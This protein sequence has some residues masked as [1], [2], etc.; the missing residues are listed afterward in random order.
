MLGQPC[1]EDGVHLPPNTPPPPRDADRHPD[2]WTPYRDRIEF[3]TAQFLYCQTQ[4][5]APNID[6]LLDLW[7]STLLKHNEPPPFAN[8][9]DLYNTIDSTPLG[10]VP[11]QSFSLRYNSDEVPEGTIPQWMTSEYDVWFRD[12]HTIVKNMI[13]NPEY[14]HHA[15]V[16]PVQIFD[17]NGIRVYQNFMSGDWAWE[18]AVSSIVFFCSHI[19]DTPSQ[20]NRIK[21]PKTQQRMVQCL[22]LSS[23]EATKP[24]CLSQ[25]AT[26]SITRY[27]C[28]LVPSTTIFAEHIVGHLP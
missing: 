28:Q 7:A 24:R 15:D 2:N 25:L 14:N 20:K 3:E 18:E 12:P 6:K 5:S 9:T 17:S 26:T 27:I 11:W 8:H 23:W 16:A 21:Y 13:D 19:F 10:D 1:S 4:M 22:S